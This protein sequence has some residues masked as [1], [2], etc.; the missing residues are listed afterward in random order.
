MRFFILGDS[1]GVGEWKKPNGVF[2]SIPDTS[3]G[4]FLTQAGH[5]VTNISAGSAGN[6]GQLRHA[7]W[8]LKEDSAY[9]YIIWFHTESVRDIEEILIRNPDEGKIQF[10][11][12]KM[13]YD[14]NKSIEYLNK[15]NYS[16]AQSIF[17]EFKIPFIIIEG[18]S[19]M[20]RQSMKE[21]SFLKF[22]IPW[23]KDLLNL[24]SDIPCNTFFNWEKIQ[25]VL[26]HYG[27]DEK[28]F[29]FANIDD[30]NKSQEIINKTAMSPAFPD[31][32]HPDA[33]SHNILANRILQLI[34]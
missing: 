8:T 26:A 10:P 17:E 34:S 33:K 28:K 6:F 15:Q 2:E 25:R 30:L 16:Y 4:Y 7:Y 12:F 18:Q 19:P 27:F 22:S 23:L 29:I 31:N 20:D 5:S 13:E 9:D 3:T 24:Q 1:W 11:D 21:F 32:V 14:F